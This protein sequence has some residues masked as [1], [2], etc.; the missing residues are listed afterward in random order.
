MLCRLFHSLSIFQRK[1]AN[2][3]S[4]ERERAWGGGR[5]ASDAQGTEESSLSA[6][7]NIY[8]AKRRWKR[9]CKRT[10]PSAVMFTDRLVISY[11]TMVTWSELNRRQKNQKHVVLHVS[12][13]LKL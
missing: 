12:C 11:S 6:I 1:K 5:E 10:W 3:A 2:E 9:S 8:H 13:Y 4:T 7:Q